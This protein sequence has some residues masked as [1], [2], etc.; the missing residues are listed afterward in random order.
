MDWF[1]SPY[2]RERELRRA[3]LESS[4]LS[5]EDDPFESTDDAI[6]RLI[7]EE[8]GGLEAAALA[9]VRQ[10]VSSERLEDGDAPR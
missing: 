9:Y 7:Y 5:D 4:A 6:V 1:G 8:E 2:P 3:R 10:H